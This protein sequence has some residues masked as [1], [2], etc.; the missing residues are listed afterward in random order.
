[1]SPSVC[2]CNLTSHALSSVSDLLVCIQLAVSAWHY[3]VLYLICCCEVLCKNFLCQADNGI[4]ERMYD[5]ALVFY[6]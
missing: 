6:N 4:I 5:I 2:F 3:L 1:M